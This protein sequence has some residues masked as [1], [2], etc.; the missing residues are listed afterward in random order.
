MNVLRI[1]M[2]GTGRTTER[3]VYDY[4]E[5]PYIALTAIYNP[6]EGSAIQFVEKHRLEDTEAF[7]DLAAF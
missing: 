6:H 7:D 5:V 2:I 4:K 3:F 1:G